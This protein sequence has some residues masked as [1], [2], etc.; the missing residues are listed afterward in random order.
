MRKTVVQ[1]QLGADEHIG[2]GIELGPEKV[3]T[4]KTEIMLY[5]EGMAD[6]NPAHSRVRMY[7]SRE[8]FAEL[9]TL[10]NALLDRVREASKDEAHDALAALE[11][12]GS[13]PS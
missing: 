11:P 5:T 13:K 2:F 4:S 6:P 10:A 8:Q 7:M 1:V 3:L 12:A 9:V